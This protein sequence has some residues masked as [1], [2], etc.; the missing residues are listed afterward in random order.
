MP[1]QLITLL[2]IA[3]VIYLGLCA[4]MYL[5]QR[6]LL[7]LPQ[8]TRVPA[9]QTDFELAG[10]GPVLRGWRLNPGQS[11]ALIY[12]GGNAEAVQ[13]QRERFQ[14]WF[15]G[16]TVY[17]LAYRGYGASEGEPS[18]DGLKADALRLYDQ[19]APLHQDIEVLA[20]S[21]GTGVA[22]YL[23]ARRPVGRLALITPYDSL[24]E[25]AA[26]HYPGFPVRWLLHQRFEASA[27]AAQV[28]APTLLLIARQD[29]II[30]P[31]H[32][33][34]LAQAFAHPPEIQ[35]LDT[36]HNTVEMDA[37]FALALQRFF[38]E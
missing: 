36:D 4:L 22:L 37:R 14:R 35:W 30:P 16:H 25:V 2:L 23:A 11:Q 38:R 6:S 3:L 13:G 29:E 19:L 5:S 1:R 21:V 26:R 17:L 18:E 34:A 8:Y 32:A 33:E 28:Q 9:Q 15:P 10:A 31:A 12:F 20:R 27:D 24:V 7:F